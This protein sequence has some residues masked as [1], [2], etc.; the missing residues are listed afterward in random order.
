MIKTDREYYYR[1]PSVHT[2]QNNPSQTSTWTNLKLFPWG[3]R[4]W[5]S[6]TLTLIIRIF[7]I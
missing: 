6:L 7:P 5:V 2:C 4:K 1:V 3:Q